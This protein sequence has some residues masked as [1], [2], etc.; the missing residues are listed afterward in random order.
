MEGRQKTIVVGSNYAWTIYN[1]RMPLIRRLKKEGYKV[2]VITQFDG[3]EKRIA[4]QNGSIYTVPEEIVFRMDSRGARKEVLPSEKP[5]TLVTKVEMKEFWVD[6][7]SV[8]RQHLSEQDEEWCRRRGDSERE[9][10]SKSL[11]RL[12]STWKPSF[13]DEGERKDAPR[14]LALKMDITPNEALYLIQHTLPNY[15]KYKLI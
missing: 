5:P 14:V 4:E 11:T 9:I 15:I 8:T 10:R 13:Q 1:F 12:Q 3:Y 2:F 7:R 6:R